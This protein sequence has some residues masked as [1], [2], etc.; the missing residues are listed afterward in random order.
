MEH[1]VTSVT[2]YNFMFMR[3]V[4]FSS[5]LQCV[6]NIAVPLSLQYRLIAFIVNFQV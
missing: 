3:Q 1:N 2:C 5:T 6:W 4:F